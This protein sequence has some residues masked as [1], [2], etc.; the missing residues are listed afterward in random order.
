M[1]GQVEVQLAAIQKLQN[2]FGLRPG[3]RPFHAFLARRSHQSSESERPFTRM[4]D[5]QDNKA[6]VT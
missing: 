5:K 4:E 6:W 2:A 1:Q 3:R